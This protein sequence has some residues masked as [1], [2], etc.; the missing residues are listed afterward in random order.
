MKRNNTFTSDAE[1]SIEYLDNKSIG[2]INMPGNKDYLYNMKNKV[3]LFGG[4]IGSRPSTT[5]F[6]T[7]EE[8]KDYAKRMN[9]LLSPGEKSYYKMRYKTHS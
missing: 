4:S 1:Q 3:T 2:P 8:A 6:N 7:P 5:T 9:K